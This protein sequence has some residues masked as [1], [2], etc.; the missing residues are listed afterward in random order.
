MAGRA[1][2]GRPMAGRPM[3]G[4]ALAALA[5]G[6]EIPAKGP[7]GDGSDDILCTI[8]SLIVE[9]SGWEGTVTP[10]LKLGED[11][12]M[13]SL[14][15]FELC[16]VLEERYGVPIGSSLHGQITVGELEGLVRQ[17]GSEPGQT[18]AD[19]HKTASAFDTDRFPQQRSG[20]D[21]ALLRKMMALSKAVWRFK[22]RGIENIP[23]QG[24]YILCPNHESHLDGLWV[25][26]AIGEPRLDL[27]KICC[28]AKKEHLDHAFS[29][30]WLRLLGGIPVDRYG[31][32]L[33]SIKRCIGCVDEGRIL[34][35]HPE[36][37]RTRDGSLGDFKEGAA[38]IAVETGRPVIPVC[39]HGAR[40]IYPP[41]R[42]LPRMFDLRKRRRY[43][44]EIS[45]GRPIEPEGKNPREITDGIREFIAKARKGYAEKS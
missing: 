1:M 19:M 25:F 45:F 33:A 23:K 11:I 38:K 32:P 39:I 35:I 40:R 41:D 7:S 30:K 37:T 10:D 17:G 42:S 9:V 6:E 36:G 8:C 34:L 44:L 18:G 15:V 4:R 24:N 27:K 28:M 16:S 5:S 29:R 14:E 26:T 31:N 20:H 13:G 43:P 3:A 2:T 12:G 21:L 22:V